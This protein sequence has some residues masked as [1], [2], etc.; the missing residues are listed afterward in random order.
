MVGD[1]QQRACI[2]SLTSW[3]SEVS[4]MKY[5]FACMDG[6]CGVGRN[7]LLLH[8]SVLQLCIDFASSP[9]GQEMTL[10]QARRG[11]M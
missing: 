3:T 4:L 8:V 9:G 2:E 11:V 7:L 6:F 10:H 5:R 1:E